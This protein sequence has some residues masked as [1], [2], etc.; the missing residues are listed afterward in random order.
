MITPDVNYLD[1]VAHMPA[2][3]LLRMD[4]VAWQDYEKLLDELGD[5]YAV[6]VSYDEGRL[7]ITPPLPEHENYSDLIQDLTRT[8]TR[9]LKLKLETRGSATLKKAPL[10]GAEPD[11]SF[12]IWN[13]E[14]I[15]GRR[16]LDLNID[17]P[18]DIIVE[19]DVTNESFSKFSIYASLGVPEIWR[20]DES[21]VEFY[22]LEAGEYFEAEQSRVFPFLKAEVL[23]QFLELSKVEG[24]DAA[25]EGFA[26]WVAKHKP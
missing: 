6:R 20:Y 16:K 18:P 1:T 4:R 24:Q 5:G 2:G 8:L 14:K 12:Y 25:L 9:S 21:Q 7:E 22:H 26:G 19:I 13:A 15:I 10:K 3:S 17:P 23:S 11:E